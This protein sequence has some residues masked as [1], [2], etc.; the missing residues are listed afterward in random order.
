MLS[1]SYDDLWKRY[2]RFITRQMRASGFQSLSHVENLRFNL[3]SEAS[4][5]KDAFYL[6]IHQL[7]CLRSYEGGKRRVN[8]HMA[9]SPSSIDKTFY[10]LKEALGSNRAVKDANLRW[11]SRFPDSKL[12]ASPPPPRSTPIRET[13]IKALAR[14]IVHMSEHWSRLLYRCRVRQ[15][16]LL[17]D[18]LV[19]ILSC[20]SATLQSKLFELSLR[21]L[22]VP[23]SLES[24][25]ISDM[26]K[27]DTKA[28]Y[29]ITN[30]NDWV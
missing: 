10:I 9:C 7:F 16:P 12:L 27:N 20:T 8:R 6:T 18:E 2:L 26:F 4:G 17:V 30:T 19:H 14:F 21:H 25:E 22:G 1:S 29:M 11:F 3:A 23:G 24:D 15:C 13:L 28:R 5:N